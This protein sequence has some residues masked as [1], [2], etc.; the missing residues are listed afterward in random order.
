M[1]IEQ[2][3]AIKRSTGR[4]GEVF[5]CQAGNVDFILA[6]ARESTN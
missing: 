1:E 2:W 3:K 4:V 5:A 6:I